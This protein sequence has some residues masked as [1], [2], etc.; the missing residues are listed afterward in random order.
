M[1]L[2]VRL[3]KWVVK[4]VLGAVAILFVMAL[5]VLLFV[6][7]TPVGGRVAADRISAIVS[8]PDRTITFSRPEGLLTGDLRIDTLTLSD[9][10]GPYAQIG[11]IKVDWSPTALAGGVFRA[12]RISAETVNFI[13][14]PRP[15]NTP[16]TP[17]TTSSSSGSPLPI[18]IRV[19]QI[20]L[21]DINLSQALSGRDFSLS[22]KGSVDATGPDISLDLQATRKDEPDAKA[23]AD[24]VYAPSENR[25]TLKAAVSEPQGG[26]L[27]RLLRLPGAPA[28]ELALD[29]EGP[30][31]DWAGKLQGSV[32]GTPVIAVD[33]KHM[34]IED[35]RHRVE[36]TGGG[37]LATL[38]P[39]A[40]RPLFAGTTD[41]NVAAIYADSGRVDIERGNLTSGAVK[42]SA[43]GVWDPTGDNSLTAGL[44]GTNGPVALV[45]PISG[46]ESRFS[47]ESINFTL[48]GA[49]SS[50]RF[51]A[52]AAL[53]A[54]E[55][56]QG[57]FGQIRLQAESEDLNLI[58]RAG[59]IRSRFT[60]ARTDFT[61]DSLDRIIGGP[62]TLDAP[63]RLAPPAIGLDAATF[64]SA[65][66]NG[67]LSG[68][69][70]MSK[71]A[72]TGNFRIFANPA[73]LP[74]ALVSKFEGKLSAEGY[75]NAATDGRGRV[76]LENFVMRSN[77]VEANGNVVL[78]NQTVTGH[79]AGRM[80]DLKRWLPEGEGAA[81]FDI[82]V[83]GPLAAMGV[84][85]VLNSADA[86]L[87]GRKLQNMSVVFDGTADPNA[88]KGKLTATGSLDGQSIRANADIISTQGRTSAPSI[89]AEVGPNK[90]NGALSFSPDFLP[91]GQLNFDFPDVSMLA[92]LAAQQA[93]GDLRG[94]VTF[95]NTDG[96]AGAAIRASGN[97]LRR[98]S[99]EIVQPNIDLAIPDIKAIAAE[100]TVRAG[101]IGTGSVGVS[102]INLDV[103]HSGSRT[104]FNL[105]AQYD[106]A[107][108]NAVGDVQT[109]GEISVG[110]E[111]FTASPR[112]IPVRLAAPTR[113]A[114]VNGGAR[115]AGLTLA[116]G[117]GSVTVNGTA[118]S[119]LDLTANINA[120]PANLLNAFVPAVNAAG[121]I[122]GT[123][124]ATGSTSAPAI[125]YDL[126]WND[127]QLRQTRDAG[128]SP[129]RLQASGSF[130]NGTVALDATRLTGSDGLD[131]SA[132]GR[133][134]LQNGVPAL[135]INARANAVPASL[136][137]AFAPTLGA[138]GTVS[139]TVTATGTPEA[140]AVRYDLRWADAGVSQ[141]ASAGLAPLN[142]TANGTFQNAAVTVDTRLSGG[143]GISLSGSGSVSLAGEKPLN[144]KFN[145]QLPFSILAGQLAAQGFVL[146]GTGNVDLAIGGTA[147]A[148]AITGTASSSGA[149]LVDVRRNLAVTDLAANI[150]FNGNSANI[151]QLSGKLSGGGSISIQGSVGITPGSGFPADLRIMLA[152][153]TYADGALFAATADGAL[154]LTGPLTSGPLL[155]GRVTLTKA[156]ITV[157]ARLP[158]S[159]AEI[160]IR[161]RNAPPDVLRQMEELRPK[162]ATGSSRPI[163]LNLQIS[164]PNGI[165]VRGRGID[166]ELGGDL[167][168][169]GTAVDPIVSGG[170]EMRRGRIVIL[171]K[172]LDFTEGEITFGGGLIP[173]LNME[174]STTSAQ[175][176]II[177]KVTGVANDPTITFSSSPALPQDEVL[178]RLIFGQ[179]MSRLS[180]LQIAQL[181]DAV[182]QLAGGGSTSLLETLRSNL[183]VDDLDIN[184]DET[185]QT[186]VSVGRYINN[187]TY[188]QVEQGGS[189]GAEATI[190]LDI[191]RGVK[192]KAGAGTEGGKAGIFYEHEY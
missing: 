127:A 78:E 146:E 89:S 53:S 96:R 171:A 142:I 90:L 157:P 84:K 133:V 111:S 181:A 191:G 67:T 46:Q 82:A 183:G 164:A 112:N 139:G 68:A 29:G 18:G 190:N 132:A 166:A 118:G 9:K 138:R 5:G 143:G 177:V 58:D 79:L 137:N 61:N 107:P 3:L 64:D 51:N 30:L 134:L 140:P 184:T 47:F 74:A 25:L 20:D 10:A 109:D 169:T 156:A 71:Q 128:I 41:I 45:W 87:V 105:T 31:S 103:S 81:G 125:R 55:L 148:P 168:I 131:L 165:F 2:M 83:N 110:I 24:V 70:D 124:N 153:A 21:P 167:T 4:A 150:S 75:V 97:A 173:V 63:L 6:A 135:D 65:N 145:G 129:F 162:E 178:A 19:A 144:L 149:R 95:S 113:I 182:T 104:G 114:I 99:I 120:L 174:A 7:L 126:E 37:Q 56:P 94:S 108:L 57:R 123:V 1:T 49:A 155:G 160:D 36:V 106:N 44:A 188:V 163:A 101:R 69:Y 34:L 38:L 93:Q 119:S 88:P 136:I 62:V 52:T 48:T 192:L 54:A 187:R 59:S 26:L 16:A 152:R 27:A 11:G 98:G 66:V 42:I 85:A 102:D 185:G 40:F 117:S 151:S 23:S 32:G 14:P 116:T 91:E 161:H 186:T 115:L 15:S 43:Q 154:T 77:A 12:E 158:T 172:R 141:T 100:G 147:S 22:V 72:V 8:T 35:G 176:T 60:V 179:S 86:R 170:F 180:P 28:V 76:S 13:R 175:T 159:L 17:Q 92:A 130:A 80:P 33:G 121:T 39:P 73:V 50:A 189:G 122:S